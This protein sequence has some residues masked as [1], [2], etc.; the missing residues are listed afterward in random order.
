MKIKNINLIQLFIQIGLMITDYTLT[1]IAF[2]INSPFFEV[3]E[4]NPLGGGTLHKF[5]WFLGIIFI[6]IITIKVYRSKDKK[7]C[8][9]LCFAFMVGMLG[10]IFVVSR[11]AIYLMIL[12]RR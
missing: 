5:L 8:F 9:A 6:C 3:V 12:L 2:S 7:Y 4:E 10:Y 1:M 11:N